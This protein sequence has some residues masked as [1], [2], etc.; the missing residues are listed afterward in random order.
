MVRRQTKI[1]P[2]SVEKLKVRSFRAEA[3]VAELEESIKKQISRLAFGS[4]EMTIYKVFNRAIS[5]RRNSRPI[6][7]NGA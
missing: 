7:A 2:C 4:L 3:L 6:T 5:L 1:G